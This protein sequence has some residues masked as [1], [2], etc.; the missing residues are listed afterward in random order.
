MKRKKAYKN[1]KLQERIIMFIGTLGWAEI[2]SRNK[3]RMFEKSV[4]LKSGELEMRYLFIGKNGAVRINRTK[5]AGESFSQTDTWLRA[6][7]LYEEQNN[8]KETLV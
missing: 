6:L 5:N 4:K 1:L 8:L 3:Y 2:E 7:E